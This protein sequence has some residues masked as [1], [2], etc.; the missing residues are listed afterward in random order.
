[1]WEI[2]TFYLIASILREWPA[3][4]WRKEVEGTFRKRLGTYRCML[5]IKMN[6]R[7]HRANCFY[8]HLPHWGKLKPRNDHLFRITG[9]L[10][11]NWIWFII[12]FYDSKTYV[13]YR[14]NEVN[15]VS[16]K[17]CYLPCFSW[18]SIATQTC[19]SVFDGNIDMNSPPH[20]WEVS[21]CW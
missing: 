9:L 4:S 17:C 16:K 13:L 8:P 12:L 15:L 5:V 1:M 14:G 18:Q 10:G 20:L 21:M 11:G 6:F 7:G 3:F 19:N 2:N